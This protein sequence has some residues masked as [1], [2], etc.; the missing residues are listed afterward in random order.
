MRSLP[1]LFLSLMLL[2]LTLLLLHLGYD[3]MSLG[4]DLMFL[5]FL[6]SIFMHT[7]ISMLS[8]SRITMLLTAILV[9]HHLSCY[10][11]VNFFRCVNAIRQKDCFMILRHYTWLIKLKW[12]LKHL[13]FFCTHSSLKI[14]NYLLIPLFGMRKHLHR[15]KKSNWANVFHVFSRITK[16]PLNCDKTCSD[17]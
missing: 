15:G 12:L 17:K 10:S 14:K 8:N 4:E 13:Q 6:Y 1:L 9:W 5:R 3:G 2:L 11:M 7:H 16:I